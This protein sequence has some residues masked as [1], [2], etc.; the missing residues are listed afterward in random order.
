MGSGSTGN[1]GLEPCEIIRTSAMLKKLLFPLR[2][3]INIGSGI[4]TPETVCELVA[5]YT[6]HELTTERKAFSTLAGHRSYIDGYIMPK[7][8]AYT[9]S[10]VRTVLV[11]QRLESLPLAPG[12]KT[13]IRNVMSAIYSHGIRHEWIN[14]NP[15]SKVRCSA[16]RQRQPDTVSPEEFQALLGELELRG[17]AMVMLAAST[18]LRRSE[19]IALR[20]SDVI[21]LAWRFTSHALASA[22]IPARSRQKPAASPFRFSNL[23]NRCWSSGVTSLCSARTRISYLPRS[24]PLSHVPA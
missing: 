22:I 23:L 2:A 9:L 19:L 8:G 17:R 7:W 16:K 6:E 15:I 1:R 12:S 13:K 14:L 11:E 3:K 4:R 21:G 5:H 24:G 18:G 20:W 10:A